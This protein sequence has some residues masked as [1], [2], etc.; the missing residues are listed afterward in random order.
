MKTCK[1]TNLNTEDPMVCNASLV[2]FSLSPVLTC[3]RHEETLPSHLKKICT[4][5]L[6]LA[7]TDRVLNF[8]DARL[9]LPSGDKRISEKQRVFMKF[10]TDRKRVQYMN[11]KLNSDSYRH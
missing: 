9:V 3:R 8:L 7:V 6:F 1:V 11:T 2:L 4:L 5:L 10:G